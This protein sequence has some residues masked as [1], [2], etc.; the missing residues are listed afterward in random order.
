MKAK[1][2]H[3]S[4]VL[5]IIIYLLDAYEL[6]LNHHLEILQL[7]IDICMLEEILE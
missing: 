5:H 3:V 1:Y 4:S 6:Q 2:M 7:V